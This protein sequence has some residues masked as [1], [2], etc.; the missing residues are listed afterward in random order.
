MLGLLQLA[1]IMQIFMQD[2]DLR[3]AKAEDTGEVFEFCRTKLFHVVSFAFSEFDCFI[4]R[5]AIQVRAADAS[6][7]QLKMSPADYDKWMKE[8]K[9]KIGAA[10]SKGL[11]E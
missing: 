1:L 3:K 5:A 6:M 10:I 2:Y 8:K 9:A 11:K 7:K 4:T